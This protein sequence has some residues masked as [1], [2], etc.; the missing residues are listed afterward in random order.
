MHFRL[1]IHLEGAIPGGTR[2]SWDVQPRSWDVL[3]CSWDVL[4]CSELGQVGLCSHRGSL[5][6]LSLE[7][8]LKLVF[9]ASGISHVSEFLAFVYAA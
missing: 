2:A 6:V 1:Q 7:Q 9:L 5:H 8:I 3:S 4:S